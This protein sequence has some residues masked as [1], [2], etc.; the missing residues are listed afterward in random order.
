M[1][2]WLRSIGLIPRGDER[3][4]IKCC[5]GAAS[6]FDDR[7]C[8]CPGSE[9]EEIST[10]SEASPGYVATVSGRMFNVCDIDEGEIEITEIAHALSQINRFCGHTKFPYSVAQHSVNCAI[11]CEERFPGR[12]ELALACLMHDAAEA[13]CGDVIRPVKRLIRELYAPIERRIQD[14]IWRRFG[15]EIDADTQAVIHQ[16]DNA[17]VMAES[18]VLMNGSESWNW[19]GVTPSFVPIVRKHHETA[20]VEF[21]NA[22]RRLTHAVAVGA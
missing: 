14:A 7:Y 10:T 15:I 3:P 4:E 1:F 9:P 8:K 13:Y 18:S 6:G 20:R 22:F 19:N 21:L 12:P 11:E 2:G 5:G 17:V 16:V